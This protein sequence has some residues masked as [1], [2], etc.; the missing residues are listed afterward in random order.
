MTIETDLYAALI[1]DSGVTALVS[2]GSPVDHRIYPQVA[3][4]AAQVPYISYQ[5]IA[6]ESFNQ[7][8]GV[9]QAERKV[10]QLN[11]IADTYAAAKGLAEAV[12]AAL[13]LTGHLMSERDDY[14]PDTQN[15]RVSLDFSLIG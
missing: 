10:I 5:L 7:N 9:P 11:C 12:K 1:A 6:T 4:D 3:D 2:S 15:H 13:N 14:F 8:A